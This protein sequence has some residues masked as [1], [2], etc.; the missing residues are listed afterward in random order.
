MSS[1]KNKVENPY[2]DIPKHEIPGV[3]QNPIFVKI[4]MCQGGRVYFTDRQSY[5]ESVSSVGADIEF[6]LKCPGKCKGNISF[7]IAGTID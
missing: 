1:K 2:I 5:E 6:R 7:T 3:V 4:N